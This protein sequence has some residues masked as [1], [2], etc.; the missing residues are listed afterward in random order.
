MK[1]HTT[2]T[3]WCIRW[4]RHAHKDAREQAGGNVALFG[5]SLKESYIHF[6]TIFFLFHLNPSNVQVGFFFPPRD[7]PFLTH[8]FPINIYLL[9]ISANWSG[10]AFHKIEANKRITFF[11]QG[12]IR[13]ITIFA[14]FLLKFKHLGSGH[15]LM[16]FTE[17][18]AQRECEG[19]NGHKT[20]VNTF[21]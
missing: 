11:F 12:V 21:K 3:R 14:A 10:S 5:S 7:T 17:V 8:S 4:R 6:K 18:C 20:K 15:N 19:V 2:A 13:K 1:L 9:L 16:C